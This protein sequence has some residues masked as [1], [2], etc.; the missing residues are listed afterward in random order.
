[1][2]RY[3][4]PVNQIKQ[5]ITNIRT[6][7]DSR[8][9][10]LTTYNPLE[11]PLGGLFPCHGVITQF[12]VSNGKLHMSTTQRSADL[13]LGLCHNW[14]SY[15][16]LQ[17]IVAQQCNL[18]PGIMTYYVND[19]HIYNNHLEPLMN[20]KRKTYSVPS[21]RISDKN[22]IDS[23]SMEDFDLIDYKAGPKI[24]LEMAI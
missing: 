16:M 2:Y 4:L 9:L 12:C 5:L 24:N 3:K 21:L 15:A 22:D 7:P 14:M 20:M 11:A 17:A 23:Y 10:L 19:L 8:R 6:N 18:E 13:G 1:M